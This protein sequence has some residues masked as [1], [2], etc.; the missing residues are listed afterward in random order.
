MTA[1]ARRR[2]RPKAC[3]TPKRETAGIP[4]RCACPIRARRD[5]SLEHE[6][7]ANLTEHIAKARQYLPRGLLLRGGICC[8]HRLRK[9]S[10][11]PT[12][13]GWG[14]REERIGQKHSLTPLANVSN[15]SGASHHEDCS[16]PRRITADQGT[17]YMGVEQHAACPIKNKQ[18][19]QALNSSQHSRTPTRQCDGSGR[20]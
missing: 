12:S 18:G 1:P 5:R 3:I 8:R 16:L 13:M 11:G 17:S 9:A 2:H 4:L 14:C 19:P 20:A 10:A 6:G 15:P 7:N